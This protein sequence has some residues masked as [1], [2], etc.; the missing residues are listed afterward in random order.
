MTGH[1][2]LP[3]SLTPDLDSALVSEACRIDGWHRGPDSITTAE[4]D[5]LA[6]AL[7]NEVSSGDPGAL[8]LYVA[9]STGHLDSLAPLLLELCEIDWDYRDDTAQDHEGRCTGQG[10]DECEAVLH[11]RLWTCL[12]QIKARLT[13]SALN[14]KVA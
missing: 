9:A 12:D 3:S 7:L 1:P 13:P 4:R 2:L 14:L 10:C 5:N 11:S 8:A 6:T